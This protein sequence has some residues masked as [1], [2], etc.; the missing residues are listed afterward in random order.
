MRIAFYAPLKPP[1]HPVPSG[2]PRVRQLC[3]TAL[4]PA[5]HDPVLPSRFRSFEGYGDPHGRARLATLG[6]RFAEHFVQ[7]CRDVPKTAP[8]LWFT[9]HLYHKAPDWLGPT[10]ADTLGLPYVVAEASDAPKQAFGPWRTGHR[11]A[12][13]AICRADTVIGINPTDREGV[14]PLLRDQGLWVAIKPFL[15]AASYEPQ[16]RVKSGLPRLITIAM[17]RRGDKLASYRMLGSALSKLRDLPWSLE[18]IGGGPVVRAGR[19]PA[20]P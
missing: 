16:P 1:D 19:G 6:A 10:I 14:A 2:E 5:A 17:M 7:R 15:D 4:Q 13:N 18:V 3:F 20:P 8:Q 9:Y 11:A 12:E